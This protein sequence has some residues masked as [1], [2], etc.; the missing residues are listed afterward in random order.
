M[1]SNVLFSFR[2]II[3]NHRSLF[4]KTHSYKTGVYIDGINQCSVFNNLFERDTRLVNHQP[5]QQHSAKK[6]T[7]IQTQIPTNKYSSIKHQSRN[8]ML[9]QFSGSLEACSLVNLKIQ[10]T[11]IRISETFKCSSRS[12]TQH[13]RIRSIQ[14]A[15]QYDLYQM[16]AIL[17]NHFLSEH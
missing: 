17:E 13:P 12:L 3:N 6:K 10:S 14:A 15:T 4:R 16:G 9:K 1:L 11:V 2:Y 5:S 8:L 7:L